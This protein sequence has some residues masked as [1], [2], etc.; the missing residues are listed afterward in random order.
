MNKRQ[1][2]IMII[3]IILAVFLE[4]QTMYAQVTLT[5]VTFC[6]NAQGEASV[7]MPESANATFVWIRFQN[8]ATEDLSREEIITD[9]VPIT[10]VVRSFDPTTERLERIEVITHASDT[11]PM[12]C[13][14]FDPNPDNYPIGVDDENAVEGE[15]RPYIVYHPGFEKKLFL[16]L[17]AR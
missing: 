1:A 15:Y 14:E 8:I 9:T 7:E 17:I 2:A 5:I 13:K 10:S 6:V 3:E 4:V 16:P 11:L 12:R